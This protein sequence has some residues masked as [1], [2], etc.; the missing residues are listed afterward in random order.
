[1][2]VGVCLNGLQESLGGL[3][4][5]DALATTCGHGGRRGR[6]GKETG[7]RRMAVVG[8]KREGADGKTAKKGTG[9]WSENGG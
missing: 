9:G 2:P 8:G 4:E 3:G 6:E 1:M 7:E 5:D